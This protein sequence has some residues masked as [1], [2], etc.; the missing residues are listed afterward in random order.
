MILYFIS[1][2]ILSVVFYLTLNQAVV[3]VSKLLTV[4]I[5]AVTVNLFVISEV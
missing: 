4:A 5:N 3:T 2:S 1:L